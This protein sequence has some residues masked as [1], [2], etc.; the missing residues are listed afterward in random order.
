M[1]WFWLNIPLS[2]AIF[3]ATAGIPLWMVLRHPDARPS[4][5]GAPYA[6][7]RLRP[8]A[9]TTP[10]AAPHRELVSTSSGAP[11]S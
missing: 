7:P 4:D 2:T 9:A 10:P 6:T 1:S 8:A 5:S 3:L 11:R